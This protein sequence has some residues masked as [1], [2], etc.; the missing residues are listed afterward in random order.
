MARQSLILNLNYLVQPLQSITLTNAELRRSQCMLAWVHHPC[1]A[2]GSSVRPT[3]TLRKKW[4]GVRWF[5]QNMWAVDVFLTGSSWRELWIEILG[6]FTCL[7]IAIASHL[8]PTLALTL[9]FT[10][11][12]LSLLS[13]SSGLAVQM[14]GIAGC[15]CSKI[16]ESEMTADMKNRAPACTL[17]V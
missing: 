17:G 10:L 7:R 11:V 2:I 13:L 1:H 9:T 16:G 6:R 12:A 3:K 15:W 8:I 5:G 14:G 4:R